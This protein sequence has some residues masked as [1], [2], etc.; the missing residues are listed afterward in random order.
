MQKR[1]DL[2]RGKVPKVVA[3]FWPSASL[4]ITYTHRVSRNI[5]GVSVRAYLL[6]THKP[7]FLFASVIAFTHSLSLSDTLFSTLEPP[8][9][10]HNK[11]HMMRG[12]SCHPVVHV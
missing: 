1:R 3:N 5:V 7:F 9:T 2:L 10:M 12:I 6:F 8:F 4:H 11:R